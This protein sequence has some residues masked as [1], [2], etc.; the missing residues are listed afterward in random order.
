MSELL[1]VFLLLSLTLHGR[2]AAVVALS[3]PVFRFRAP[4]EVVARTGR[5]HVLVT[6]ATA[7]GVASCFRM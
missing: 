4:V 5:R 3:T 1:P 7:A 6:A 2:V